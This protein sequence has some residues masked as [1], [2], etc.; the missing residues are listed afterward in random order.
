VGNSDS[1][2]LA[3]GELLTCG[4]QIRSSPVS[5]SDGILVLMLSPDSLQVDDLAG[6]AQPGVAVAARDISS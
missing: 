5:I 6:Q 3:E 2:I 4:V 1:D